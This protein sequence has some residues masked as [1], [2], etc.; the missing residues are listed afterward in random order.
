V[1]NLFLILGLALVLTT[2]AFARDAVL[3]ALVIQGK[4]T[5]EDIAAAEME[6][7]NNWMGAG[8]DIYITGFVQ[9][10]FKWLDDGDPETAIGV[11]RARIKATG[12]LGDNWMFVV[13]T[14]LADGAALRDVGVGYTYGEGTVKMGQCKVPLLWENMTNSGRL[15][16]INRAE[17]A[18]E[19]PIR[20]IGVFWEHSFLD[21]KVGAQAAVTNGEGQNATELNDGKDYYVRVAAQP[22]MG[23]ENPAD[24]LTV[25]GAYLNGSTEIFELEGDEEVDVGEFDGEAWVATV[26]WTWQQIK[27]QGEYV[28]GTQDIPGGTMEGDGWYVYALYQMPMDTMTV[29]PVVKYETYDSNVIGMGGDWITLG[30]TLAFVGRHDVKLEANYILEDLDVG[31]DVDELILQLTANF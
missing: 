25:A 20:D 22:F 10:W 19:L 1:K 2:S 8:Y 17:F 11:R 5:E 9:P 18:A 30:V 6:G 24:G 13:E 27:V 23:S 29:I 14:D 4:V 12:M 26:V 28:D 21:G 3:D 16:T 15:D 7:P 31:E